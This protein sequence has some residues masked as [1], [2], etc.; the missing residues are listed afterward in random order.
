MIGTAHLV[1]WSF[2]ASY[3]V[4][5]AVRAPCPRLASAA[6][7]RSSGP[8]SGSRPKPPVD[9]LLLPCSN[10][11][12]NAVTPITPSLETSFLGATAPSRLPASLLAETCGCNLFRLPLLLLI[13]VC[14]SSSASHVRAS[15][16]LSSA[17]RVARNG[18]SPHKPVHRS[19]S[20]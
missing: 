10:P 1:Q 16:E 20:R 19:L 14:S 2:A 9:P 5:R 12:S 4:G 7:R 6:K 3:F 8:L 15:I 17:A 18:L 13:F 11:R